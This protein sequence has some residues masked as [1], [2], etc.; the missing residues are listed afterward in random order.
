[1]RRHTLPIVA[2][3]AATV[4]MPALVLG[5]AEYASSDPEA[6]ANLDTPPSEVTVTFDGE[7]DPSSGFV[8]TD[9]ADIEVGVG[10]LDLTVAD[11]NVLSGPVAI[12]EPG[13]YTVTFTAASI[14]GHAEEGHFSFGYQAEVPADGH[15]DDGGHGDGDGAPDTALPAPAPSTQTVV[16]M[17][18]VALAA[19][20]GTRRVVRARGRA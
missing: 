6:E 5:H 11:R 3:L 12:T 19:S 20:L 16:G 14:D 10:E 1:M 2:A 17:A 7:L 18:L 4:A 8:V 13:V 9:A 15:G